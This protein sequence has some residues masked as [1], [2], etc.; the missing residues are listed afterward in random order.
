MTSYYDVT[1]GR[2]LASETV[3][4][5]DPRD[6]YNQKTSAHFQHCDTMT[7][8]NLFPRV[9]IRDYPPLIHS[10]ALQDICSGD[11]QELQYNKSS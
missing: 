7:S 10:I 2:V 4:I 6:N 3:T 5:F 9:N 8:Y 1:F 11:Y